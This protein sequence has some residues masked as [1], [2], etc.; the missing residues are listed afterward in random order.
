VLFPARWN[1]PFPAMMER[2]TGVK[3]EN[4]K[5]NNCDSAGRD[6]HGDECQCMDNR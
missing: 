1:N 5:H 6:I 2:T 3:I 4:F